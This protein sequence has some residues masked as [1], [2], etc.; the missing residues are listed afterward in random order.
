[1]FHSYRVLVT[2][3]MPIHTAHATDHTPPPWTEKRHVPSWCS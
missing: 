2:S 1:M 3:G